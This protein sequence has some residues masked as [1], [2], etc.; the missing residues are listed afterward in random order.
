MLTVSS[1][2]PELFAVYRQFLSA[3]EGSPLSFTMA[4]SENYRGKF[5]SF[6]GNYL[7]LISCTYVS[8][9][10][11]QILSLDESGNILCELKRLDIR[12][13]P[14]PVVKHSVF[15][16]RRLGY[17]LRIRQL[18]DDEPDHPDQFYM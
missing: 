10:E 11:H 8:Y 14:H 3:N 4:D 12:T 5:L 18:A 9:L 6:Y 17:R 2:Q 15:R 7:L 16:L 1:T 13:F